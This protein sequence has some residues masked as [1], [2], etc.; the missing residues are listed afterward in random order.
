MFMTFVSTKMKVSFFRLKEAADETYS[1][2][3]KPDEISLELCE[4]A[5]LVE[6]LECAKLLLGAEVEQFRLDLEDV[7]KQKQS[8]PATGTTVEF[9]GLSHS[10]NKIQK[11]KIAPSLSA[12]F[13][14]RVLSLKQV[15]KE[16]TCLAKD[17]MALHQS[18]WDDWDVESRR[19]EHHHHHHQQQQQQQSEY[20]RNDSPTLAADHTDTSVIPCLHEGQ[21]VKVLQKHQAGVKLDSLPAPDHHTQSSVTPCTHEGQDLGLHGA[22]NGATPCATAKL[23]YGRLQD[24]EQQPSSTPKSNR[25]SVRFDLPPVIAADLSSSG[26][27]AEEEEESCAKLVF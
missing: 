15:L 16:Q 8:R 20:V 27:E 22:E 12:T 24:D 13:M 19:Q 14:P 21:R 10:C 1:S 2:S 25:K 23:Q 18:L 7:Q 6:F 17:L 4:L 5:Q 9:D 11:L 3:G 26:A